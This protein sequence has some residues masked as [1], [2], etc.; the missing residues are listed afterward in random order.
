[1]HR[2]RVWKIGIEQLPMISKHWNLAFANSLTIAA[3]NNNQLMIEKRLSTV[4]RTKVRWIDLAC[5]ASQKTEMNAAFRSAE[6][7]RNRAE[8]L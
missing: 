6:K 4:R 8:L 1:M 5:R 7:E 3:L 2:I